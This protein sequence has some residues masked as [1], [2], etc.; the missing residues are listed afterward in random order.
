MRRIFLA[1]STYEQSYDSI[2][3]PS[4]PALEFQ[5]PTITDFLCNR[6]PFVSSS[7]KSYPT[8]GSLPDGPHG[9]R[10]RVSDTYLW[11]YPKFVM[12]QY[13]EW[14]SASQDRNLGLISDEWMGESSPRE[15]FHANVSGPV[16]RINMDGSFV[17][18]PNRPNFKPL[19]DASDLF[20]R[21][22]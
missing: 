15:G 18:T 13:R 17:M 10:F 2:P 7:S 16:A 9:S 8:D 11:S 4:L 1:E 22:H 21:R 12:G 19:G 5:V 6:D 20:L 14:E 3:A